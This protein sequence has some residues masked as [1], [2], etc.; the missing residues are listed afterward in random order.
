MYVFIV[1]V[2]GIGSQTIVCAFY[3]NIHVAEQFATNFMKI[4]RGIRKLRRFKNFDGPN[5]ERGCEG[6]TSLPH[7]HGII[8]I[9][10]FHA[11]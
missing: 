8:N 11:N 10:H 4:N 9:C 5:P 3:E 1:L 6:M 2:K 7:N